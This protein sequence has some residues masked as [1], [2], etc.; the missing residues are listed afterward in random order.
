LGGLIARPLVLFS[1]AVFLIS[2]SLY[3]LR[4]EIFISWLHFTKWYIPFAAIAILLSLRSHGG[5]GIGNIFATEIV[6][7][8]SAGLFFFFS[9]ILLFAKSLKLRGK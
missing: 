8:W 9:V 5:W 7:M 1:S 2:S 3:F 6:T 4:E